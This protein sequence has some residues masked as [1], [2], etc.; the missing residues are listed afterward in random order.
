MPRIRK[1]ARRESV[2]ASLGESIASG[3]YPAGAFLPSEAEL[4]R[5]YRVSR[6]T[7]RA[8]LN[9]LREQGQI[10]ARPGIGWQVLSSAPGA[11]GAH[12][13]M[14]SVATSFSAQVFA[15][16]RQHLD[17]T[18]SG[19]SASLMP[20]TAER[21]DSHPLRLWVELE[22][23][24]GLIVFSV[25]ALPIPWVDEAGAAKVPVVCTGSPEHAGYDTIC[26]DNVR[27]M[28]LLVEE[29]VRLGHRRIGLVTSTDL[30]E[31]DPC[32]YLRRIGFEQGM[33]R[34]GATASVVA[35]PHNYYL[36]PQEERLIGEWMDR[37]KPTCLVGACDSIAVQMLTL[38]E[39]RKLRVP[40]DLSL[41]GF[42]HSHEF[43]PV[44]TRFGLASL[45]TV[46]QPWEEI[47][48]VAAMRLL[49]RRRGEGAPPTLTL[50]PPAFVPGDS[51]TDLST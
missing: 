2:Q 47:G 8:A 46:A 23:L 26:T 45:T 12:V 31:H 27:G 24:A 32:F 51:V 43:D 36:G 9:R 14:L 37:V 17:G 21:L 18:G 28:E 22:N 35:A 11:T 34:A 6:V 30:E 7:I 5:R 40:Q 16:V 41:A 20:L 48:R 38:L 13:T 29:L 10:E 19:L 3:K 15:G 42:D 33:R 1:A 25:R 44:L 50:I 39:R 4:G 49:A